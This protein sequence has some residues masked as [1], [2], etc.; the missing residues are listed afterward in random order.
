MAS[1]LDRYRS[2]EREVVWDE[3]RALGEQIRDEK[4]LGDAL[5][6]ARETMS[7]A[8]KNI[9][10]L[11]VR[12]D[13][14]GYQFRSARSVVLRP[15]KNVNPFTGEP[16]STTVEYY[17]EP[18]VFLPPGPEVDEQIAELERVAGPLPLSLRAWYEIV[19]EV[20]FMGSN[21]N[22]P[23]ARDRPRVYPDPLVMH[24]VTGALE[25]Y[26]TWFKNREHSLLDRFPAFRIWAPDYFTKEQISGAGYSIWLPNPAADALF[27]GERHGVPFVDYLRI[28]FRWGGFPGFEFAQELEG[29]SERDLAYLAEGL[30]P[31]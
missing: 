24:S 7:R 1:Y 30:L 9:E 20:N 8:R 4:V 12:L 11:I 16:L 13:E 2:G 19:G 29:R 28:C 14:I 18:M 17:R 10:R 3:L 23:G 5:A 26:Q 25:D 15:R 27:E 22:W 21:P 31:I 6:V